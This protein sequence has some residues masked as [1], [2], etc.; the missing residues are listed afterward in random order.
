[1]L[2][3]SVIHGLKKKKQIKKQKKTHLGV[4]PSF[5]LEEKF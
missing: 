3:N 1:M 2:K 5:F 4:K